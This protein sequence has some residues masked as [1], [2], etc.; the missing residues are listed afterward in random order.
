MIQRASV[1]GK[2]FWWG[3]VT[4]LSPEDDRPRVGSHLQTLLRKELVHPDRS[5]FAGEDAFRF[6][7]ILVRDAAYGS[8]PK[9]SRA[10][11]HQR[12]AGWLERKAGDRIAEFEEIVGYH[13][14]HAY[15]YEA[16]LGP[17]DDEA[18]AVAEAAAERLAAAGRRALA[19]WDLS[20]TEN[21]LSRA[22]DLLPAN[23][24]APTRPP[25]RPRDGARAVGH[26]ASGGRPDRGGR[27]R[28]GRRRPRLGGSRRRAAGLRPAAAGPEHHPAR[29]ARRGRGVH[30]AL[31]AVGRRPRSGRGRQPRR[32]D[33]VLA[34]P[35]RGE[36]VGLRASPGARGAGR[37]S[38][39]GGRDPPAVGPRDRI[40]PHPRR[41]GDPPIARD[42]G[43]EPRGSQGRDRRE[44]GARGAGGDER[45][46]PGGSRAHRARGCA[47]PRAGRSGRACRGVPRRRA[48]GDVR[49]RSGG[50]GD[51]GS[52]RVRDPRARRRSRP[53]G[54][55]RSGPGRRDL[56]A[57]PV[58]RGRCDGRVRRAAHD[59]GR[60]RR[61]GSRDPA[62]ARRCWL[63]AAGPTR[64][65][66]SRAR[67][68]AWPRGPTT[69]S[70]TRTRS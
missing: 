11:L 13:L 68:C 67:R 3:A 9:R 49:G 51:R 4:E 21:L 65:W 54:E 26:P 59:R 8:M 18:R 37:R 55:R 7:H 40:G 42:P 24:S 36:R 46:I 45:S 25:A 22:V 61:P 47:G 35:S 28:P 69:S 60:R 12:F 70:S 2:I 30:G 66:R 27:G 23:R 5:G 50:G 44:P 34:R 53:P 52:T 41:R 19:N 1:V 43:S 57:G 58:R 14:E 29:G 32:H 10:D 38:T 48:R 33:P 31:R 17:V 15:R 20:A 64:R 39:P 56:R 16:E 63:G 62:A 6:S